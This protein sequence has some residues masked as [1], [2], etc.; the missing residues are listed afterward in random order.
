MVI[1]AVVD[2]VV[3][4]TVRGSD[5]GVLTD[6]A[7]RHIADGYEAIEPLAVREN[8]WELSMWRSMRSD[9]GRPE[10]EARCAAAGI[11]YEREET[12]HV[13]RDNAIHDSD[14]AIK[15]SAKLGGAMYVSVR[16]KDDAHIS[17][18]LFMTPENCNHGVTICRECAEGWEIDYVVRYSRTEGGRKLARQRADADSS[19]AAERRAD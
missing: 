4:H 17:K 6:F 9:L 11:T 16:S 2:A 1:Y 7:A 14:G 13:M 19:P 12:R 3:T 15:L 5:L 18:V 10:I 8:L